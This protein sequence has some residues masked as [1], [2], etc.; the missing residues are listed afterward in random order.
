MKKKTYLLPTRQLVWY[1]G[2]PLKNHLFQFETAKLGIAR[3]SGG[4]ILVWQ[5]KE[6][7]NIRQKNLLNYI[8]EELQSQ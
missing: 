5:M 7:A 1:L 4:L 2:A 8:A 6:F 3:S